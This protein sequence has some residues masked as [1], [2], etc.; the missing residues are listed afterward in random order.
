MLPCAHPKYIPLDFDQHTSTVHRFGSLS[1]AQSFLYSLCP[2]DHQAVV[3]LVGEMSVPFSP[4]Q[5]N[6]TTQLQP[7]LAFSVLSNTPL[8]IPQ[9]KVLPAAAADA[10]QTRWSNI[11]PFTRYAPDRTLDP[12]SGESL[13][14]PGAD[15]QQRV[16]V[17]A[18]TA[19]NL[20]VALV[21]P[22]GACE[23]W[24]LHRP[25]VVVQY[26]QGV[27]EGTLQELLELGQQQVAATGANR[28]SGNDS[29]CW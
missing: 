19:V 8:A 1:A 14:S 26:G 9:Y 6:I 24:Q 16:K 21:A 22:L 17:V 4:F 27:W 11:G 5:P 12:A 2:V 3:V 18:L 7:T 25:G 23:A 29:I 20:T 10:L 13:K 28:V 15:L